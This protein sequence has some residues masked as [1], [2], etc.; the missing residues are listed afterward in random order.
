MAAPDFK[1]M[2]APE[3]TTTTSGEK[4]KSGIGKTLGCIGE[5]MLAIAALAAAGAITA[6]SWSYAIPYYWTAAAGF[7]I[8][9][10]ILIVAKYKLET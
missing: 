9:G 3:P 10:I 2:K 5:L 7:G 8:F 4:A 6:P 1:D